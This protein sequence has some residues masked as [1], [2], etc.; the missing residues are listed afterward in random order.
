MILQTMEHRARFVWGHSLT[1]SG[2]PFTG[3]PVAPVNVRHV[4]ERC[5]TGK[6]NKEGVESI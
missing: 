5:Q 4:G 6:Y 1:F 3:V 2:S